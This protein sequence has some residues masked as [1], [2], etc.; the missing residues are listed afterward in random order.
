[1]GI[2]DVKSSFSH[3]ANPIIFLFLGGFAL[4][5]ALHKQNIDELI[6]KNIKKQCFSFYT[7]LIFSDCCH[8]HVD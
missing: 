4:A 6:A 8:K 3:F 5:T 1:M 2:F 7:N